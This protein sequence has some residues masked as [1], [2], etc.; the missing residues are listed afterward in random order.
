MPAIGRDRDSLSFPQGTSSCLS[1]AGGSHSFWW[2]SPGSPPP[3]WH[4]DPPPSLTQLSSIQSLGYSQW[5]PPLCALPPKL[6]PLLPTSSFSSSSVYTLTQGRVLH[7]SRCS[8]EK[9]G[10]SLDSSFTLPPASNHSPSPISSSG[11]CHL[12]ISSTK[13]LTGA[14]PFSPRS[15]RDHLGGR[16]AQV[17]SLPPTLPSCL[18][19]LSKANQG[20]PFPLKPPYTTSM[21][22]EVLPSMILSDS[23][24]SL[25]A[26]PLLIP[27]TCTHQ[28][29]C[30]P[31]PQY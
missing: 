29:A 30:V 19:R 11:K 12:S 3:Q 6:A 18:P 15:P 28:T 21:L 9:T 10:V 2:L 5:C 20:L 22:Q 24:A 27:S 4:P 7:P 8:S 23:S 17:L 1:D 16:P 13:I 26:T 14:H 25:N 31:Q